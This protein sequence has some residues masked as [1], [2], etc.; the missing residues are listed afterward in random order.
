MKTKDFDNII[1][2]VLEEETRKLIMEQINDTDHLID[3]IKTFQT[4]SGLVEKI[5]DVNR[6]GSDLVI[7]IQ[8]ITPEE[9]VD[10]CGGKSLGNAQT[11][12]MQ[13]LHHDLED[14]GFDGNY[15]IDINTQGDE[16]SLDLMIMISTNDDELS[17]EKNI[18]EVE[19]NGEV[20]NMFGQAMYEDEAVD[21]NPEVE[22]KKDIILGSKEEDVD[23]Q[24]QGAV[25]ALAGDAI[26][27]EVFAG[28]TVPAAV[29]GLAASAIGDKITDTLNGGDEEIDETN[30][31]P[32]ISKKM[33]ENTSKKKTITLSESEM[34]QLLGKIIAEAVES[35][36]I[37][38]PAQGVPGIDVTKKNHKDSGMENKEALDAVEEKIRNYLKFDGNDDPEFPNPIGQGEEK[39]SVN[40]TDSQD[41]EIEM[42]RGRNPADLT[43]DSEPGETFKKRSKLSLVGASEMGNAQ[44][45]KDGEGLGNVIPSKT[46]EN[47]AKAAEKRK[48]IRKDESIYDKEAV[49][50]KETPNKPNR[51]RVDDP[52]VADNIKR[53]KQ[54]SNYKEKTQ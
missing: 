25:G 19:D 36:N 22:D 44:T 27:G 28:S 34:S 49:P 51:P 15:D 13:G 9:L 5:V 4:L 6:N 18:D 30:E 14:N 47:I 35:P 1:N 45:G 31:K 39:V 10:C 23:E 20:S 21:T 32:K 17:T 16:N 46:G 24:W 33:N 42:N 7:V 53:M 40:A 38:I 50:V 29:Q 12:L 48:E 3:S 11:N 37:P 26:A 2:K 54:M 41:E 8:G 52:A 43:Y